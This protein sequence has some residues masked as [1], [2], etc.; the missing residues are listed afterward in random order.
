MTGDGDQLQRTLDSELTQMIQHSPTEGTDRGMTSDAFTGNHLLP[1]E[2]FGDML[3]RLLGPMG[4][5]GKGEC[6]KPARWGSCPSH[7]GEALAQQGDR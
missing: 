6:F 5:A 7:P 3:P 1:T 4:C 2:T